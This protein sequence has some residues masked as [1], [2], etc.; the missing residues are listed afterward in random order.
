[1]DERSLEDSKRGKK[2]LGKKIIQE[3]G[4][5]QKDQWRKIVGSRRFIKKL[6]QE[7]SLYAFTH[8]H[9]R[10]CQKPLASEAY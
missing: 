3:G 8:K 6:R 1:M 10:S 2:V 5:Q 7:K 9:T 4:I